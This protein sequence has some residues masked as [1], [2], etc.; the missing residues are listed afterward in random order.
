MK[1]AEVRG[2]GPPSPRECLDDVILG[3][4]GVGGGGRLCVSVSPP[5]LARWGI[6]AGSPSRCSL[7]QASLAAVRGSSPAGS[8]GPSSHSHRGQ[9]ANDVLEL[10]VAQKRVS[11]GQAAGRGRETWAG[12]LVPLSSFQSVCILSQVWRRERRFIRFAVRS[13]D[14]ERIEHETKPQTS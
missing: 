3:R 12:V 1:Q 9:G 10:L 7:W 4:R 5:C 2:R 13:G 8:A 14:W 6:G 11:S